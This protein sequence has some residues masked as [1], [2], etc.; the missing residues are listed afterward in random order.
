MFAHKTFGEVRSETGIDPFFKERVASR[1][2]LRASETQWR[3][4]FEV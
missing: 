1:T 4:P 2:P 3:R